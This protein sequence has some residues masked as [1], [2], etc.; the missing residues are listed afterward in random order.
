MRIACTLVCLAALAGGAHA[1]KATYS[2]EIA[3]ASWRAD[4]IA[5]AL[6]VDLADERLVL[7]RA[8]GSADWD[9]RDHPDVVVHGELVGS[10]LRFA[11]AYSDRRAAGTLALGGGGDRKR[12]AGELR[13][14]LHKIVKPPDETV[15]P[16]PPASLAAP[17]EAWLV[18]VLLAVILA[19]PGVA[20]GVLLGHRALRL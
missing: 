4:A 8:R 6:R 9:A 10:S 20:G 5:A 19:I 15:Q 3:P 1:G 16:G 17:G 13:D 18:F 14:R 2:V 11:I 7:A 12:L